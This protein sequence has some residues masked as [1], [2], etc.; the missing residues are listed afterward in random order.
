M[1]Q[2]ERR[3]RPGAGHH[4]SIQGGPSATIPENRLAIASAHPG[5]ARLYRWEKVGLVLFALLLVGLGIVTEIRSAFQSTPKTDFGVYAR[6]AWAVRAGEDIYYHM[7]DHGWHYC[8]PPTFAILL[9]PLANPYAFLPQGGYLPFAVSVAV[10]YLFSV[11]CVWYATHAMASAALPDA[12][13]G[14]RRWW[15]ARLVPVYVALGGIGYTLA[16]GQVNLLLVALVAGAFAA[17]VK[18]R[19]V[20][21]GVWLAGAV[22]LKMIPGLLLLFP[23]VRRD[24]RTLG[25]VALGGLVLLGAIPA[26]V[27]GVPKAI[28]MNWRPVELVLRPAVSEGG[29]KTRELELTG[30]KSTDSQ[31]IRA[32]VQAWLYPN[33][34][35]RPNTPDPIATQAHWGGGA[36]MVL[37]TAGVAFRRLTPAPAD[38]LVFLGCLCAVMMILTPVS[39]MH[40]YAMVFPLVCGL[41]LRGMALRP[42]QVSSSPGTLGGLVAWGVLTATPLFPGPVFDRLRECGLG[43]V[44][45]IGLWAFGLWTLGRGATAQTAGD[46]FNDRVLT[47]IAA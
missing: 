43:T 22:A 14:S 36:L 21:A 8:Y 39:H 6:A 44:A 34:E 40:Y 1:T 46:S 45:T 47:P 41:W 12:V 38:Q 3:D 7:D 2:A 28:E 35:T 15:Y 37:V 23:V 17:T 26:A 16:R 27:W 4:S 13:R 9:A 31:S 5:S 25:G 10:W 42:G 33:R 32:V 18:G 30:A 24:G 20:A 19:R 11:M 29:D